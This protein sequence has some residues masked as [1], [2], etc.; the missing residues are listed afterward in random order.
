MDLIRANL[1]MATREYE[2]SLIQHSLLESIIALFSNV[3]DGE[4]PGPMNGKKGLVVDHQRRLGISLT[5]ILV[6]SVLFVSV[7]GIKIL[8]V[9]PT[10]EICENIQRKIVFKVFGLQYSGPDLG[11]KMDFKEGAS[12]I[13]FAFASSAFSTRD[14]GYNR[15]IVERAGYFGD[16]II[17]DVL[18]GLNNNKTVVVT[19]WSR[20][21]GMHGAMIRNPKFHHVDFVRRFQ[22]LDV[23]DIPVLDVV[24][25]N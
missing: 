7:P 12:E 17:S 3:L 1:E 23:L 9:C 21:T 6:A 4:I 18:S 20:P 14:K 10:E 25:G 2:L 15:I 11:I 16:S 5:I 19:F 13:D 24:A 8:I 22:S